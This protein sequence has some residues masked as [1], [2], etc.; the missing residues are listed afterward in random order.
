LCRHFLPV[1]LDLKQYVEA[2]PDMI[3]A[4]NA[5]LLSKLG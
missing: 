5:H 2:V 4:G 3:W 1:D